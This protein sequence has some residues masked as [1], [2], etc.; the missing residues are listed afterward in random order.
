MAAAWGADPPVTSK[1]PRLNCCL[2][3]LWASKQHW[4]V[5]ETLQ[6]PYHWEGQGRQGGPGPEG[7]S[8][9]QGQYQEV[10]ELPLLPSERFPSD[11]LPVG[12]R[13]ELL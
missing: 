4:R 9:R 3:Y 12:V 7:G 11:H 10:E 8:G 2:D 5:V 6:L 13:L 1:T